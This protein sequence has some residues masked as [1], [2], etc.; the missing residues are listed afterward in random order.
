M[1]TVSTSEGGK[2]YH[3]G[4]LRVAALEAGLKLLETRTADDLGLRE[5]ARAVGVS[6]TALYRHF[7][8][9]KALMTAL[10]GEGL[11]RLS[12]VQHEAAARAGG[13]KAGFAAT[14]AAYVRFALANPALFR[15]I[16][17]NP[18]M[19]SMALSHE[20]GAMAFL[21]E[22]ARAAAAQHGGDADAIAFHAWSC[23][24]GLAM[25]MLDR[26]IPGDDAIID[27]VIGGW[28]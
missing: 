11:R 2:A 24:H 5:I 18:D 17:A 19:D 7:P 10:A 15:L 25:L 8:D 27:R 26:Q 4:D 14:G 3:H 13:G 20:D 28:S 23:A 16:F 9:K 22:N 6:A 21:K 12:D 1:V